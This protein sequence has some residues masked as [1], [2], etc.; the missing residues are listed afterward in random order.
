MTENITSCKRVMVIPGQFITDFKSILIET[1]C[2]PESQLT[3]NA[4]LTYMGMDSLDIFDVI[5]K[6]EHKFDVQMPDSAFPTYNDITIEDLL[7]KFAN[8]LMECGRLSR[9]S[10]IMTMYKKSITGKVAATINPL[11]KNTLP[12]EL[13]D[14][15]NAT[16]A[17]L[18]D[19]EKKMN[20]YAK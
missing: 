13:V 20:Q 16:A 15:Y 12:K 3:P 1:L 8:K 7:T 14:E 6:L 11:Q 17:K 4:N 2:C 10:N 9:R 18:H 5:M 19:L